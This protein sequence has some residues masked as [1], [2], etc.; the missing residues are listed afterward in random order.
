MRAGGT[1]LH[2][3]IFLVL[4]DQITRGTYALGTALPNEESLC[5]QFGVSRVTVRRAL[6]DL[7]AR[8]LVQR[9][10]G[11]GTFVM[12][13]DSNMQPGLTLGLLEELREVSK[14]TD[15]QVLYVRSEVP[16]ESIGTL[17]Q[18]ETGEKAIT[19]L[20]LRKSGGVPLMLIEAWVPHSIGKAVSEAALKKEA[21]YEILIRQ[22]IGFGRIIQ[23]FSAE[24]ADATRAS[25][26][27]TNL[28]APLI[29]VTRLLHDKQARPVEYVTVYLSPERSRILMEV[30]SDAVNTLSG[31]HA[32]HAPR[33]TKVK[34]R[35]P[36][37]S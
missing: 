4:H 25:L 31:G 30:P 32:V 1:S 16:P 18:L 33:F 17:L 12:H 13:S 23:E 3:Q 27:Q 15:V 28:S 29:R 2:R 26:L 34:K 21:L 37:R 8:G 19:A 9:R 6:S 22:G 35:R 11:K 10:H 5:E 7:E 14:E 36:S 24:A 20:R